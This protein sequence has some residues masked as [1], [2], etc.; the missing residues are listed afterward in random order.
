MT[1]G[2]ISYPGRLTQNDYVNCDGVYRCNPSP[3]SKKEEPQSIFP[4]PNSN[5][6]EKQASFGKYEQKITS[7]LAEKEQN[8]QIN[9]PTEGLLEQNLNLIA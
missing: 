1:I 3:I 8:N 2:P 9:K 7:P 5:K 4:T 6:A